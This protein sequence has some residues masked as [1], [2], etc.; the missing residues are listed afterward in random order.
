MQQDMSGKNFGY[1]IAFLIPGFIGLWGLSYLSPLVGSWFSTATNASPTV[2][3][4]LYATIGSITIGLILHTLRW[5]I[6]DK[7]HH[8]TGIP[9][10][11]LDYSKLKTFR[12][13]YDYINEQHGRYYQFYGNTIF[14]II[15]A[16]TLYLISHQ[17]MPWRVWAKTLVVLFVL[18]VLYIGSRD[19]L[20]KVYERT[21]ALMQQKNEGGE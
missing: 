16:Y 7:I 11:P 20:K 18:V 10:S 3:G 17:I 5:I 2:G 19:T 1:I 4:F 6:L 9:E 21:A 8:I 14:A 15:L 12:K 13:E